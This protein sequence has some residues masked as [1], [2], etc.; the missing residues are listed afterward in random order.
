MSWRK[1]VNRNLR[2]YLEN[3][4]A[5]S[6]LYRYQYKKAKDTSKAQ[7]WVAMAILARRVAETESKLKL[8]EAVL[9]DISP[10]KALKIKE[11][12]KSKELK[13]EVEQIFKSI[14]QGRPIKPAIASASP[15]KKKKGRK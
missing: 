10:K 3:V 2:P 14:V 13:D 6:F 12:E 4:I 9:K 11:L 7:L 15:A 5:E 1:S 8:Y